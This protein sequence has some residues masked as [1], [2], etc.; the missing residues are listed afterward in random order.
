MWLNIAKESK[1]SLSLCIHTGDLPQQSTS[2][3]DSPVAYRLQ[4]NRYIDYEK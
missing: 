1:N 2:R 3:A 4:T